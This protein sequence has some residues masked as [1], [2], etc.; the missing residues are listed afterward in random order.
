MTNQPLSLDE[1]AR[2]LGISLATARRM[3][4]DGRIPGIK[5]GN[6]WLIDG[7][8]LPRPRLRRRAARSPVDIDAAIQHVLGTDL[9]ELWVPDV[10]RHADGLADRAWIR[11]AAQAKI[12]GTQPPGAAIE[13]EVDKTIA[14]TRPGVLLDIEDR[15]AFQAAVASVANQIEGQT[16][17]QVFSAR[18]SADKRYFLKKG[19][20][21]WVEWRR[22]VLAELQPSDWLVATDLTA[23]FETIPHRDLRAEIQSL[24][25][26]PSIAASLSEM[27]RTWGPVDGRGLPQG[28]NAS[29]LLGNMHLLPVDRAMLGAGYRY[30][31]YMD[32]IRIVT[33]S[34]AEAVEAVRR[35]QTECR[36]RG[37]IISSAKTALFV[38]DGAKASLSEDA[39]LSRAQYF[40]NAKAG[41]MARKELKAILTGA[42]KREEK[43]NE[44]HVKFSLWRLASLGDDAVLRRVMTRLDDLAPVASVVA[45]YLRSFIERRSVV[46]GLAHFLAD[47][48]R[49]HSRFLATWL[50][51]AMLEHRG[52]LP[53]AWADQ[54]GLR[55]RDRNE[56]AYLRAVASIVLARGGR[57]ADV[58]WVKSDILREH[59]PTVLRGYAVALFWVGAL[60]SATK[61]RLT[62]RAARLQLV[63]AYLEGRTTLPSLVYRNGVLRL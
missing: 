60:D 1:A 18:L 11:N 15:V 7:S 55:V 30:S 40:L 52:D 58:D 56:P 32:D 10:I 54:A 62:A 21:Q 37:L 42:L 29:R 16:P 38:G 48:E 57:A 24:N 2:R 31:R 12:D 49:S 51:A 36:N 4:A 63:V 35:F 17:S 34:K 33:T 59:D 13:L 44:R 8:N 22:S 25:A 26:H 47:T 20:Q 61:R 45:A 28:P 9:A 3:A 39:D 27:L 19:A 53:A 5:V 46:S 50:F 14:L 41:S 23:Y 43:I 6:R